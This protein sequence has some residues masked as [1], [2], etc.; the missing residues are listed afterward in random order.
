MPLSRIRR[1]IQSQIQAY[2]KWQRKRHRQRETGV[3]PQ[4][5]VRD[6]YTDGV[7]QV[8]QVCEQRAGDYL[9]DGTPVSKLNQSQ[10][11]SPDDRIVECR[12]S[13]NDEIEPFPSSHLRPLRIERGDIVRD[14]FTGDTLKIRGMTDTVASEIEING[15]PLH[16]YGVNKKL[17][18]A[19]DWV[20]ECTYQ[21][22]DKTHSFPLSRLAPARYPTRPEEWKERVRNTK[23]CFSCP[24]GI[25]ESESH[26]ACR[27]CRH[28]I[29]SRDDYTCQQTGC[30]VTSGLHVHHLYYEPN[31][32]GEI[33]DRLLITLCGDCHK[34]RHGID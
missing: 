9:V 32:F 18:C 8:V 4:Q 27:A 29:K 3:R 16:Q 15:H 25:K 20:I 7:V 28:R 33:P 1:W 30:E 31:V 22:G 6:S 10:Q 11:V 24:D 21:Y 5:I 19:S 23:K 34:D 26:A 12:H 13:G 17:D 14:R 2:R